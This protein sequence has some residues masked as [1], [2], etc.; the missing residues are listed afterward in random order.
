MRSRWP[1]RSC[2]ES[3]GE[4][5][6]RVDQ[7]RPSE[8]EPRAVM[9][10]LAGEAAQRVTGAPTETKLMEQRIALLEDAA[11]PRHVRHR[12]R[13]GLSKDDVE[14]PPASIGTTAHQR[15]ILRPEEHDG[16][17]A[18]H[19]ARGTRLAVHRHHPRHPTGRDIA[20]QPQR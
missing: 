20:L 3:C 13:I 14:K 10:E 19:R 1:L 4:R 12:L 16:A 7:A 6:E 2:R 15:E 5:R 9:R 17:D 8:C 18:E 11:V